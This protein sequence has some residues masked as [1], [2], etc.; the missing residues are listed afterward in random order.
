MLVFL[1]DLGSISYL[2]MSYKIIKNQCDSEDPSSK[3]YL[4]LKITKKTILNLINF[5]IKFT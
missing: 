1:F 3:A 4:I 5:L 2:K